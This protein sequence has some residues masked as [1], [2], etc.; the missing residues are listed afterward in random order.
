MVCAI[1]VHDLRIVSPQAQKRE[2]LTRIVYCS[3]L[4]YDVSFACI[5]AVKL[6]QQ[7]A[8]QEKKVG[9][10]RSYIILLKIKFSNRARNFPRMFLL[11]ECA[12]SSSPI[13]LE[14]VDRLNLKV[15]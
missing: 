11:F 10:S 2:S 3:L 4:G 14:V 9:E 12:I 8:L 6:A 13:M 7:G 15:P 5:H 1:D